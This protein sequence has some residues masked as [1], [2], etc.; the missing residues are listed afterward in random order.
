[1]SLMKKP[2]RS[3]S[4]YRRLSVTVTDLGKE[5]SISDKVDH[6]GVKVFMLNG[7]DGAQISVSKHEA[8]DNYYL[9]FYASQRARKMTV[10]IVNKQEMD[11]LLSITI[12]STFD[13]LFN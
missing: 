4:I 2:V 13:S 6:N 12:N 8:Q 3:P 9:Y 7:P 11:K 1:M 10:L 5:W